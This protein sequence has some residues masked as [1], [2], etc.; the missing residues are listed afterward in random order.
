M[1]NP[2]KGEVDL[3]VE[4]KVYTLRFSIDDICAVEDKLGRGFVAIT[5]SLSDPEKLSLSVIRGLLWGGLRSQH[6]GMTLLM[7][8]DLMQ[9]AGGVMKVLPVLTEALKRSFPD[10]E[11]EASPPEPGQ[12]TA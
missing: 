11:A 4:G 2:H 1:A 10:A 8:G 9:R 3:E 6:P 5:A 7:A 12:E